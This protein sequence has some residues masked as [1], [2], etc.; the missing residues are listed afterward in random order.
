MY[1]YVPSLMTTRD[2]RNKKMK[3]YQYKYSTVLYGVL[4]GLILLLLVLVL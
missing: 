1:L 4:V 3:Q 2:F